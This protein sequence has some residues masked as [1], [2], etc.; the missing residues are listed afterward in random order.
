MTDKNIETK[1][2]LKEA[3]RALE[4]VI[5]GDA[6]FKDAV[7][8]SVRSFAHD[9]KNPLNALMGHSQL[10]VNGLIEPDR[11]LESAE[12][13]HRAAERMLTL[14]NGMLEDTIKLEEGIVGP[15]EDEIQDFEVSDII[16]EVSVLYKQMAEDRAIKLTTNIN[17]TFPTL[18]T[19]PQHIYRSLTNILSN[20]MKFTHKGGKVSINAEM[21]EDGDAII[22][23]IRDSGEGIPAEQLP[24]I[25][26][27]YQTTVSAR[28]DKGTGLGL[29]IVNQLMLELGG[30]MEI[31][32][33]QNEGTKVTL[34][35]PRTLH[36]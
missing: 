12:A 5:A 10:L 1:Q 33:R 23:V 30:R 22:F 32:S 17:S 7:Q 2:T 24:H 19:V 14:C 26:K 29:P 6:A 18:H 20:A 3:E 8:Q 4:R 11:Q 35:F 28:G 16:E 34:R 27:P 9:I 31:S 36:A 15:G 25:L 13:I 21:D